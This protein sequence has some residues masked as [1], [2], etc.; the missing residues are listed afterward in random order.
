LYSV[1]LFGF[2]LLFAVV[3]VHGQLRAVAEK[4]TVPRKRLLVRPSMHCTQAVYCRW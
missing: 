3:G 2:S 4:I 1:V